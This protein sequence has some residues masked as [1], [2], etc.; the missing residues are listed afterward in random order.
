MNVSL[1][2]GLIGSAQSAIGQLET[3]VHAVQNDLL[4]IDT[5]RAR[6]FNAGAGPLADALFNLGA[7]VG[8]GW[9]AKTYGF[10]TMEGV[11]K[12]PGGCASVRVYDVDS[13]R[14]RDY[15]GLLGWSSS[16]TDKGT[17][18]VTDNRSAYIQQVA[19]QLLG[20]GG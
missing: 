20:Y 15:S 19:N 5:L 17:I 12:L 16:P 11:L 7:Q 1:I 10:A 6:L 8:Q 4:T 14:A 2:Q 18:V 9:Q 13:S 3:D